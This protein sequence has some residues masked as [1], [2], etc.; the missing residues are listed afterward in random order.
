MCSITEIHR[1]TH[2]VRRKDRREN[3][4]RR[5]PQLVPHHRVSRTKWALG[6]IFQVSV[7]GLSSD[8]HPLRQALWVSSRLMST[9]ALPHPGYPVQTPLGRTLI[10]L[11]LRPAVVILLL[12]QVTTC[13]FHGQG[14]SFQSTVSSMACTLGVNR[15]KDLQDKHPDSLLV[16]LSLLAFQSWGSSRPGMPTGRVGHKPQERWSPV[17]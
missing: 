12:G 14:H 1:I 15:R 8:R 6:L 2:P 11:S 7:H 4:L 3:P 10:P 5:S 13:F 9:L 17:A 16:L